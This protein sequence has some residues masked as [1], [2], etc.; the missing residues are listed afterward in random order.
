MKASQLGSPSTAQSE[1]EKELVKCYCCELTE[2]CTP[3]YIARVKGEASW[4]LDLRTL[5]GGDQGRELEVA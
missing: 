1:V 3:E 5:C 4:P 2:E